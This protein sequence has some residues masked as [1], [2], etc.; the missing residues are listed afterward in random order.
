M[1]VDEEFQ[2]YLPRESRYKGGRTHKGALEV[3]GIFWKV[4]NKR[5]HHTPDMG[6]VY[7]GRPSVWGNPFVIGKDGTR[8]EVIQKFK[9]YLFS[10]PE[11]LQRVKL[12]LN[13][14]HL[15]C[16]CA[17]HDCHGRILLEVANED[18]IR[19]AKE[20]ESRSSVIESALD[21]LIREMRERRI[22]VTQ[23]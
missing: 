17:P 9:D 11:L 12:E 7:I 2:E 13:G 1:A 21:T 4:F 6:A 19:M 16:F 5:I 18:E 15:M 10:N 14:R 22:H 20:R 8:E 3:N 23:R